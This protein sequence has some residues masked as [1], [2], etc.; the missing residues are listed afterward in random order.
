MTRHPV[1]SPGPVRRRHLRLSPGPPSESF[2]VPRGHSCAPGGAVRGRSPGRKLA[3]GRR[4]P[5]LHRGPTEPRRGGG[6]YGPAEGPLR[7]RGRLSE[8][9]GSGGAAR[10]RGSPSEV[11]CSTWGSRRPRG[12]RSARCSRASTRYF[13]YQCACFCSRDS[14]GWKEPVV[15]WAGSDASPPARGSK[16]R[17][18]LR[19]RLFST[20]RQARAWPGQRLRVVPCRPSGSPR[21]RRPGNRD[22]APDRGSPLRLG[23]PAPSARL[24]AARLGSWSLPTQPPP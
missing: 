12:P 1:S 16:A 15:A 13:M 24:D 14:D 11:R 4:R 17:G 19:K 9:R 2:G 5:A 21:R 23:C 22:P 7:V 3:L 10:L 18:G 8:V 20:R 6:R